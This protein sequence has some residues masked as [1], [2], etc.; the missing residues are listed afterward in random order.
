MNTAAEKLRKEG[1]ERA[2][3]EFM[4]AKGKWISEGEQRGEQRGEQNML[5]EAL[6][7]KFG[8]V[9]PELV[10]KVRSIQS[11]ETLKGLFRQ[12]FKLD[13]LEAFTKELDKTL[14]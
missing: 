13:S 14:E 6:Q 3:Q 7:E 4:Q 8:P 5:I 11:A 9:H 1:Y 2:E 10:N 12:V